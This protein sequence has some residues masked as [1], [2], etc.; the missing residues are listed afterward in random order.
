MKEER[1]YFTKKHLKDLLIICSLGNEFLSNDK[2]KS[3]CYKYYRLLS[4]I[5]AFGEHTQLNKGGNKNER[6]RNQ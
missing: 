2:N 1:T 6:L 5:L 4:N 3:L